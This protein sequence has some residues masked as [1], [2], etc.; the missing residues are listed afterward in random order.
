MKGM[1]LLD[2]HVEMNGF[3]ALYRVIFYQLPSPHMVSAKKVMC[4]TFYEVL[5]F[6]HGNLQE[7]EVN[8]ALSHHDYTNFFFLSQILSYSFSILPTLKFIICLR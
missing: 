3:F 2:F 6:Y 8:S 7:S 4:F 1:N 5:F